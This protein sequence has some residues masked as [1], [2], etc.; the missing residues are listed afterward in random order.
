MAEKISLL[1]S[2]AALRQ[3]LGTA[4]RRTIQE[5]N[6]FNAEMAKMDRLY[7]AIAV[8]VH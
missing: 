7:Q 3:Q 6:D 8:K 2:D 5:R 1:L 4:G